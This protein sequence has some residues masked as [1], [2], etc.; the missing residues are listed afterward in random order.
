M[1]EI[2]VVEL[3]IKTNIDG[4]TAGINN[5]KT[6]LKEAT[7]ESKALGETM[8]SSKQSDF[9]NQLSDG[10]GKL[11]PAFGSAVKGAEGLIVKMWEMVANPVGAILAAVVVTLKFLYESFQSSVAG[12]K[13]LKATFAALSGTVEAGKDAIFGLGRAL[14]GVAVA[15]VKFL[16]LDFKG[17][18]KAWAEA[19]REA[20]QSQEKLGN[21]IDGTTTIALNS[22][23]KRQQA[24]D[25]AKKKQDVIDKEGDLKLLKARD[26]VNDETKSISERQKLQKEISVFEQKQADAR[27]KFANE[28]LAIG[29]AKQ[30]VYGINSEQSKKMNQE[31]RDLTSTVTE[32]QTASLSA[33]LR[34]G[35]ASR[36]LNRQ[37]VSENKAALAQQK[38]DN[39]IAHDQN[40]LDLEESLKKEGLTF[41]QRRELIKNDALLSSKERQKL[42]F[43]I[44]QEE[45]K[46]IE[47]HQKKVKELN[48]KFDNDKLNALANT[49][50]KKEQLDYDRKIAEINS[51]TSV[52]SEKSAL[53]L[54][55]ND[56]HNIKMG[57]AIKTDA[58]KK[59]AEQKV[60]DDK[61][62]A[63]AKAVSDAKITIQRLEVE[64]LSDFANLLGQVAGQ[65]KDLQK[66]A[67]IT[68]AAVS[69]ASIIIDY[70][71]G[72]GKEVA[73]KGIFGIATSTLLAVKMALSIGSVIAA[74]ATGLSKIGKGGSV[75]APSGASGGGSSTPAAPQFN[76]VG[77]SSTNQLAQSIGQ[78]QGQPIK[79]Y[80]VASDVT[81]QQGLTRNI[82]N[83][84][85]LGT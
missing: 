52:E 57:I 65:N 17:A 9:I 37:A 53:L 3:Q 35:K 85:T 30:V 38:A 50:V 16:Q 55:L 69:I 31:I 18:N 45:K 49:A 78:Q 11:N 42:N 1:A 83:T 27:L 8:S 72:M 79:A 12:G 58:D 46:S 47:E 81:T 82:V 39:K 10:V 19:G 75:S 40:L 41:A 73:T 4:A 33:E 51:I 66:A 23:A 15:A 62:V 76:V 21:I 54:K 5:L 7:T 64:V 28:D 24:N 60:I 6:G 20:A 59:A 74:T 14:I 70:N 25:I 48:D 29:K 68:Q 77:A 2:K 36:A 67:L 26:L 13:E 32:T 43:T 22:L 80:V 56:E 61:K 44:D 84:A 71:V 34:I 63:D